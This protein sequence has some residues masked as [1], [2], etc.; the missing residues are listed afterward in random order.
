MRPAKIGDVAKVQSGFAFKSTTFKTSGIRLLRNTNILPKR[1]YWDDAAFL[2]EAEYQRYPDYQIKDG[3]VLISLDR[4]IIN[5]GF[6]VARVTKDDLPA[7][8]VQRVGRFV[9]DPLK[10]LPEY[11]YAFVQS[12]SFIGKVTGHDQSLGVPHISPTQVEAVE[13]PLPSIT[14]QEQ[15]VASINAQLVE[16]EL[17]SIGIKAQLHELQALSGAIYRQAYASIL[18]IATPHKLPEPPTGWRWRK[19]SHVARLESGHTPSRLRPDWWGGDISWLSLTEIRALDGRWVEETQLRTN[20]EG[21][22]NSAARVLPRGTVC[23]SRTASVGFVA[24]MGKPMATSQDFANW[25]CGE[26]LDPDFLM[27]ALIRSRAS[28]REMAMGATH[29]TIYMPAL[30]SFHICAPDIYEQRR[31]AKDLK[32][33]LAEIETLRVALTQCAQDISALPQRILASAFEI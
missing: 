20:R 2:D 3:D 24:I 12:N 22:A 32:S 31:I 16:A 7:L 8:L 28:L 18:P 17:A 15:M 1:V 26:C 5:S 19:L 27:H 29:K 30:E 14:R 21:I 33:Q 13:L 25:V 6:K 4:P 23:L 9:I 10:V 11:L